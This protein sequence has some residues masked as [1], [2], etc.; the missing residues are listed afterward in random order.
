MFTVVQNKGLARDIGFTP[1]P[2]H[3]TI[4]TQS[5]PHGTDNRELVCVSGSSAR[6]VTVEKGG[7]GSGQTM[8]TPDRQS[9]MTILVLISKEPLQVR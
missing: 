8:S 4:S 7:R 2:D 1:L 5:Y 9:F 6:G 3:G